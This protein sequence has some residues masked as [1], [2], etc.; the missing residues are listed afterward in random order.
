MAKNKGG[1]PPV[2]LTKE[3]IVE[4]EGLARDMTISQIADYFGIGEST[5]YGIKNRDSRVLTAYKKGKSQGIKYVAGKL[6]TLIDQ[7]DTTATIFY[8]KTQA[9][10]REKQEVEKVVEQAHRFQTREELEERLAL[11]EKVIGAEDKAKI[12]NQEAE[13]E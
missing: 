10:W 8:L 13:N 4:L 6:R 2:E 1:R 12:V 9:G 5:F 7:G 3:Q 11:L